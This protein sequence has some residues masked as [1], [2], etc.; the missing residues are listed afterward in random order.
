[1]EAFHNSRLTA[2]TG[3]VLEFIAD[4]LTKRLTWDQRITLE[5]EITEKEITIAMGQMQAWKYPGLNGFPI[6]LFCGL[7]HRVAKLLCAAYKEA[8]ELVELSED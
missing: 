1:M 2:P 4:C 3:E 8:L 7:S 5:T 6:K